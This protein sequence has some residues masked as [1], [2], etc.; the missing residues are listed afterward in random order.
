MLAQPWPVTDAAGKTTWVWLPP[1]TQNFGLW[2]LTS[3]YVGVETENA[4]ALPNSPS[5]APQG[6]ATVGVQFSNIQLT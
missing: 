1:S 6:V 5:T 2:N 4:S 3:M